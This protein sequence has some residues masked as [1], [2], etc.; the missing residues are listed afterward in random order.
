MWGVREL[1]RFVGVHWYPRKHSS[2]RYTSF[3]PPPV[4]TSVLTTEARDSEAPFNDPHPQRRQ[5]AAFVGGGDGWR[6]VAL[7]GNDRRWASTAR[8]CR[9]LQ[10]AARG[11]ERAGSAGSGGRQEGR[12]V[13]CVGRRQETSGANYQ[14]AKRVEERATHSGGQACTTSGGR[15]CPAAGGRR[16]RLF[17]IEKADGRQCSGWAGVAGSASGR[18]KGPPPRAAG[19]ARR[20]GAAVADLTSAPARQEP[21]RRMCREGGRQWWRRCYRAWARW[22][23]LRHCSDCPISSARTHRW[24]TTKLST[25]MTSKKS[26]AKHSIARCASARVFHKRRH[27]QHQPRAPESEHPRVGETANHA[28]HPH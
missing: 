10:P 20:R 14:L 24:P 9:Q 1:T 22:A 4:S 16:H 13:E 3:N 18:E 27:G 26:H 11:S 2:R 23:R 28:P 6:R 25:E 12:S 15:E 19:R 8:A 17:P 7:A 5:L 21:T